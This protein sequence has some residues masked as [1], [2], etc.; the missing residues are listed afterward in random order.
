M[1]TGEQGRAMMT[2]VIRVVRLHR[3]G[4]T[5]DAMTARGLRPGMNVTTA[6]NAAAPRCRRR[7]A[8][9]MTA[10]TITVADRTSPAG[11]IF[12]VAMIVAGRRSHV[13][14]RRD[15]TGDMPR[16]STL[17]A[18]RASIRVSIR[19]ASAAR[20]R[21]SMTAARALISAAAPAGM[22]AA[23]RASI[24]AASAA[25]PLASMIAAARALI[26]AAAPAGMIAAARASIRAMTVALRR[27]RTS[28]AG[29]AIPAVVSDSRRRVE[30]PCRCWQRFSG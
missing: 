18:A 27:E 9:T 12:R 26:F 3:P 6:R 1:A 17:A 14:P 22:I 4:D 29:S 20:P 24:R 19:A 30:D 11:P 7:R 13:A 5:M 8:G 23:A 16:V 2:G 25:R 10:G 15:S 28:A 21:A